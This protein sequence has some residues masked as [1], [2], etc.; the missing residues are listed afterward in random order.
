MQKVLDLILVQ[1]KFDLQLRVLCLSCVVHGL[2]GNLGMVIRESLKNLI[3]GV[4]R[5]FGDF[6]ILLDPLPLGIDPHVLY[7]C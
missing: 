6:L 5:A 1:R 4:G 2:F 7:I 3:I